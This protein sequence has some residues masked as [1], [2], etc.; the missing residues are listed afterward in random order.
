MYVEAVRM[1]V[2]LSEFY[3]VATTLTVRNN[4]M[5][6]VETVVK[7]SNIRNRG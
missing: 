3:V 7:I 4:N 6:A 5:V 1:Y 2:G